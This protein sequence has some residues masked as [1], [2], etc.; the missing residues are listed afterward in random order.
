MAAKPKTKTATKKTTPK[1]SSSK[2]KKAA[3]H[4]EVA[5]APTP[6]PPA[7][8]DVREDSAAVLGHFVEVIKGDHK[9]RYGVFEEIGNDEKTAVVRS[10][11]ADS[12]RFTC[13]VADLVPAE[14]G[15]R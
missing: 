11:D 9:G 15:R 14:A 8:N 1:D 7:I 2:T 4:P 5:S 3:Q 12:L 6:I 10:R 13:P